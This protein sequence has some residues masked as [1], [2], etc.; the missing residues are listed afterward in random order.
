[1]L[2]YLA[3]LL[4]SDI[5][6]DRRAGGEFVQFAALE[7]DDDPVGARGIAAAHDVA[8]AHEGIDGT[9]DAA[10]RRGVR[11]LRVAELDPVIETHFLAGF[12]RRRWRPEGDDIVI[13]LVRGGDLHQ[14][15]PSRAPAPLRRYPGARAPVVGR[16]GILVG[17]KRWSRCIKPKP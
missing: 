5:C 14:H 17:G 4:R 2:E 11:D 1:V 8:T 16:F 10:L 7:V 15:H 6:T 3:A 12:D 13:G 9:T